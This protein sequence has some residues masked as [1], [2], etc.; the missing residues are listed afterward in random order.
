MSDEIAEFRRFKDLPTELRMA[1][2]KMCLPPPI[3]RALFYSTTRHQA[4]LT[5]FKHL[6]LVN[7]EANQAARETITKRPYTFCRLV[8]EQ[9]ENLNDIPRVGWA[10][11]LRVRQVRSMSVRFDHN[12]EPG[13]SIARQ[14]RDSSDSF[15]RLLKV[16]PSTLK[17]LQIVIESSRRYF[18]DSVD[19]IDLDLKS[20]K[21]HRVDEG[22]IDWCDTVEPKHRKAY[23][24]D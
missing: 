12:I 1:I 3:F 4:L 13:S 17:K 23:P 16:L 21:L 7:Q 2:W 19:E 22:L 20:Y 9:T 10:Y 8:I 6:L 5:A 11:E 15:Q 18:K 14:V 24:H